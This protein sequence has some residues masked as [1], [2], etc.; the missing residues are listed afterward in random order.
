MFTHASDAHVKG[1][2]FIFDLVLP[3]PLNNPLW[4]ANGYGALRATYPTLLLHIAIMRRFV[5]NFKIL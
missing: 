2:I 3:P 5:K 4:V 1:F